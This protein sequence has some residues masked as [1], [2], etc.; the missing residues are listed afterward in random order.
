MGCIWV[1]RAPRM[2]TV[3]VSLLTRDGITWTN[4]H[5]TSPTK[6]TASRLL[7]RSG[8]RLTARIAPNSHGGTGAVLHE[9]ESNLQ[10]TADLFGV[11]VLR[12]LRHTRGMKRFFDDVTKRGRCRPSA[13]TSQRPLNGGQEMQGK[14]WRWLA[15]LPTGAWC[16]VSLAR[17]FAPLAVQ[18]WR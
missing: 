15:V 14:P 7:R 4:Y 12:H 6:L 5:S 13:S 1:A 2:P 8:R 17:C 18:R 3:S 9:F 11:S 10:F 16:G